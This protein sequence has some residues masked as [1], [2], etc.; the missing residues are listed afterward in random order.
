MSNG[1]SLTLETLPLGELELL[2]NTLTTHFPFSCLQRFKK[3]K[4]SL[5]LLIDHTPGRSCSAA[6]ASRVSKQVIAE[7]SR[8][9][10]GTLPVS[11]ER[12]GIQHLKKHLKG[13]V[14][15]DYY[16]QPWHSVMKRVDQNLHTQ[17]KRSGGS[18]ISIWRR[19]EGK[20]RRRKVAENE[21]RSERSRC[22]VY[23]S[24]DCVWLGTSVRL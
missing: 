14:I 11:A 17:R 2:R 6:M 1:F 8:R 9:I 19:R 5:F 12:S 4:H 20:A 22:A 7:A 24:I 21:L 23:V 15:A 10:F 3:Q 16:Q 13:P 18:S